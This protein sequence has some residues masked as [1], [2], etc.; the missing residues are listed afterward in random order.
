MIE[1]TVGAVDEEGANR[2]ALDELRHTAH[3]IV[4]IVGDQHVV[5][6]AEASTLR[7]SD[8]AIGIAEVVIRPA[9]INQ[10]RLSRRGD[11]ERRLATLDIDEVDAEFSASNSLRIERTR[12]D[13]S[14]KQSK[15]RA[16]SKHHEWPPLLGD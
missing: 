12:N 10:Q 11:E 6:A 7:S 15:E 8:N 5:D 2:D 16:G 9:G 13:N 1:F 3:V 14:G 4:V